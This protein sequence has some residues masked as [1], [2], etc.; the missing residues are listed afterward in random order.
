MIRAGKIDVWGQLPACP[1]QK[2]E[3][4]P[5]RNVTRKKSL[6][7][8]TGDKQHQPTFSGHS[9][10][11]EGIEGTLRAAMEGCSVKSPRGSD[12]VS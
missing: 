12:L 8:L 10:E 9:G 4:N 6:N 5:T 11:V 7:S 2:V 1:L 3:I